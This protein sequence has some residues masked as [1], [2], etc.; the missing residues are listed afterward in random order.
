VQ[1]SREEK[2]KLKAWLELPITGI[3]PDEAKLY[4]KWLENYYNNYLVE[5]KRP[6]Y[7]EIRLA[8]E[9]ELALALQDKKVLT[10]AHT[11]GSSTFR[12]AALTHKK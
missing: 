10:S 12:F 7:Y 6:C 4:C 11:T 9:Q 8:T 1:G 2:K 5:W 3:T